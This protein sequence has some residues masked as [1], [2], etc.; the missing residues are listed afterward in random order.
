MNEICNEFCLYLEGCNYRRTNLLTTNNGRVNYLTHCRWQFKDR[1][2]TID[3]Y[4]A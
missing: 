3:L 4:G 1:M 2:T